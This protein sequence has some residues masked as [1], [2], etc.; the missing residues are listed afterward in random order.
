MKAMILAAGLG[1]RLQELTQYMPKA[2]VKVD[3]I[4]LLERAIL[5]LKQAGVDEIV[6]NAHH[7]A[8]QIV[9]F[10]S[11]HD[12]GVNIHISLEEDMLLDTG[13]GLK[14]A[15]SF[16]DK[17]PFFVHN[18][19]II[20]DIDLQKMFHFHCRQKA[21]ATLAI[22]N[23]PMQRYLLFDDNFQL[24]GTGNL[25]TNRNSPIP[26][27]PTNALLHRFGFSGIQ[28]VSPELCSFMPAKDVFSIIDV[29]LSAA[30]QSQKI[31]GFLH[32]EGSWADM[33]KVEDVVC[34]NKKC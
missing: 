17:M 4:T 12:F 6:I 31:I 2:L 27:I 32:N 34:F 11:Q 14:R 15:M 25:K 19:D 7:F 30:A 24:C 13:G 22:R 16:F 8:H 21:L 10:V 18:V 33:G 28:V 1:T 9:D 5:K 29:Y 3:G 20:S 26:T 23:R